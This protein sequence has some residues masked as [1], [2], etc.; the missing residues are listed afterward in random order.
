MVVLEPVTV[1]RNS[2]FFDELFDLEMN[3]IVLVN[4]PLDDDFEMTGEEFGFYLV[5]MREVLGVTQAKMSQLL[6][7]NQNAYNAYEKG[8]RLP[9]KWLI[10]QEKLQLIVKKYKED[11]RGIELKSNVD[12]KLLEEIVFLHNKGKNNVQIGIH[13]DLDEDLVV[14]C[15][16]EQGYEPEVFTS[17]W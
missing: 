10:I 5:S 3:S 12:E 13:L 11:N 6:E 8:K 15:L 1:E 2:V 4:E 7:C 17:C 9:K 16:V 14:K